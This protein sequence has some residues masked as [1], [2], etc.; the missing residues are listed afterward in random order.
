MCWIGRAVCISEPTTTD[1][2]I[3]MNKLRKG[4]AGAW[5]SSWLVSIGLAPIPACAFASSPDAWTDHYKQVITECLGASQ[6]ANARPIGKMFVF[7]DKAGTAVMIEGSVPTSK[8]EGSVQVLCLFDRIT[9]KAQVAEG[10]AQD[11]K[12]QYRATGD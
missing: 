7:S 10:I 1:G 3:G 8:T 6:L 5:L 4:P 11:S 12:G 9:K 2:E